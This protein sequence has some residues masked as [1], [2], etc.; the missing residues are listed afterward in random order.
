MKWI[1]SFGFVHVFSSFAHN[2]TTVYE[3]DTQF[4]ICLCVFFICSQWYY[5]MKWI[6]SF[7]SVHVFLW[8]HS[9]GS[10][11]VFS[12]FALNGN[13]VW[14][15]YP[16]FDL[17]MCFNCMLTCLRKSVVT[18]KYFVFKQNEDYTQVG[19]KV[20]NCLK[21]KVKPVIKVYFWGDR[22]L[23]KL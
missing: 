4:W 2:G 10:V 7:R 21:V 8:I 14:S 16:V 13:T 18:Q 22:S 12:S 3:V 20:E 9:F 17:F 6:P 23:S 11:D 5:S 1:P 15:G 19:L